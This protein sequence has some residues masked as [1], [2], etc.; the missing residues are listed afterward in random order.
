VEDHKKVSFIQILIQIEVEVEMLELHFEVDTKVRMVD[1]INMK[2]G[3]MEVDKETLEEKEIMEAMV[4]FIKIN[5]QTMIQT[6]ITTRNLGT[7][8]ISYRREHDARNGK[9]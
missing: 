2:V 1:I 8:Q 7:W 9:L 5:N 3:L 4:E 6:S